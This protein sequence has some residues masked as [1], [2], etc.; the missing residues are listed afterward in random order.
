MD[1]EARIAKGIEYHQQGRLEQAIE[2]YLAAFEL[3]PTDTRLPWEVGRIFLWELSRPAE[4]VRWF[5]VALP[6]LDDPYRA[7]DTRYQIGLA[8]V[9]LGDDAKA[10]ALFE[11][12]L[13]SIPTHVFACLE[14]GKLLTRHGEHARAKDLLEQA[15]LHNQMRSTLP[16]MF[17]DGQRGSAHAEALAWLNLGRLALVVN[18]GEGEWEATG[19]HAVNRLVEGLEDLPRARMLAREA[20]EAGHTDGAL[21]ALDEL[22]A[23]NPDDAEGTELWFRV[24][25]DDR[26]QFD[27]VAAMAAEILAEQPER[28]ARMVGEVLARRPEHAGALGV[29][30][31]G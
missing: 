13:G 6:L 14:L 25:L 15:V 31:R 20:R 16:E 27:E 3:T 1:A 9:F 30:R 21:I 8:H 12:V 4:A 11:E 7:T 29:G 26:G 10:R 22:L 18:D 2:A 28:A 17:P 24:A 5:E 19:T 23:F